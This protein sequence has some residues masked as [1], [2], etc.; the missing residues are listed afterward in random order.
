LLIVWQLSRGKTTR[1]VSEA[2]GYS[3]EWIREVSRCYNE[4]GI[5]ELGG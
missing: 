1:E 5:E 3:P 2:A 4:E